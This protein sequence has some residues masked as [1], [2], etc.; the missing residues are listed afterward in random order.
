[1]GCNLRSQP[2]AAPRV[3]IEERCVIRPGG[4]PAQ[5]HRKPLHQ[6]A[7]QRRHAQ[8]ERLT[9]SLRHL[10]RQGPCSSTAGRQQRRHVGAGTHARLHESVSLQG[11]ERADH[12]V[13]RNPQLL[14]KRSTGRQTQSGLQ[15][16]AQDGIAQCSMHLSRLV[17]SLS[18]EEERKI[19]R[20]DRASANGTGI[21]RNI[22]HGIGSCSS[23]F[24][25]R[26]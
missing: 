5:R 16:P 18:A 3:A 6:L 20:R 19:Q 1:M 7:I 21:G 22:C 13:A 9:G 12:G 25:L 11:L 8:C 17:A 26:E 14:G 4:L 15:A 24:G 10:C 2:E 23:H